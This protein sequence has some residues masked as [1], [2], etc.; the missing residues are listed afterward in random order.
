MVHA[1]GEI[2]QEIGSNFLVNFTQSAL[3][4]QQ[5]TFLTPVNH[6]QNIW[7]T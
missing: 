5:V 2:S 1:Q 3:I 4:L 6:P 7:K